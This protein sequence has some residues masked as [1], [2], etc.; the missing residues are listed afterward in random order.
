MVQS[1]TSELLDRVHAGDHLAAEELMPLVY[2]EL[3]RLAQSLML[4]ERP[5]HTLQATALVNE[6]YLRLLG[7]SQVDWKGKAHF[8]AIAAKMIRR[9]LV[10]YAR[11]HQRDKRGGQA[12]RLTLQESSVLDSPN[13]EPLDVLSLHEAVERL[14]QL[15]ERQARVV[16]LRF[17]AG[18]SVEETAE[19]LHVSARTIKDDWRFA[20]AWLRMQL[21]QEADP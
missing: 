21:Q 10:D 20:K 16:E 5:D 3:R 19:I 6:A 9:V 17:F 8:R 15:N 11:A 13:A 4:Q 2:D 14:E 1:Q 7:Q 12:A 18:L